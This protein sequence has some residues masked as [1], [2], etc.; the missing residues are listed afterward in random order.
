MWRQKKKSKRRKND[1][2]MAEAFSKERDEYIKRQEVYKRD[3]QEFIDKREQEREEQIKSLTEE[4]KTR[5]I[6]D[7]FDNFFF[8]ID[9]IVSLSLI[10]LFYL[11]FFI[12]KAVVYLGFIFMILFPFIACLISDGFK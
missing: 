11:I 10:L 8:V 7:F 4:D 3:L 6:G 2:K 1:K 5:T 12:L 9:L